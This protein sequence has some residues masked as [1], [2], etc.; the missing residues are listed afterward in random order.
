MSL[1]LFEDFTKESKGISNCPETKKGTARIVSL[2][3]DTKSE[4]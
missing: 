2:K 3:V 1:K 4:F